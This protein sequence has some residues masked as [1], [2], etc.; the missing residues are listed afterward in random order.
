MRNKMEFEILIVIVLLLNVDVVASENKFIGD[1]LSVPCASLAFSNESYVQ[2][3]IDKGDGSKV[4]ADWSIGSKKGQLQSFLPCRDTLSCSAPLD[5]LRDG[6][7]FQVILRFKGMIAERVLNIGDGDGTRIP[8]QNV[9]H[10]SNNDSMRMY[11]FKDRWHVIPER[12]KRTADRE[13]HYSTYLKR[14]HR[15][16]KKQ[17]KHYKRFNKYRKTVWKKP[18]Q[19]VYW[20]RQRLWRKSRSGLLKGQ[21]N[22]KGRDITG[23][24]IRD[25]IASSSEKMGRVTKNLSEDIIKLQTSLV[26]DIE[27]PPV[28][29]K[30]ATSLGIKGKAVDLT[31]DVIKLLNS[32][33]RKIDTELRNGD[34][35]RSKDVT[36]LVNSL[37]KK[38]DPANSDVE[39]TLNISPKPPK[40]TKQTKGTS[41]YKNSRRKIKETNKDLSHIKRNKN[42]KQ[43]KSS[44]LSRQRTVGR[45]SRRNEVSQS[46]K[47]MTVRRKNGTPELEKKNRIKYQKRVKS[48]FNR[49]KKYR[50][51]KQSLRKNERVPTQKR[52][53]RRKLNQLNRQFNSKLTQ[54]RQ[55]FNRITESRKM[56]SKQGSTLTSLKI[57]IPTTNKVNLT[58]VAT[59]KDQFKNTNNDNAVADKY[60]ENKSGNRIPRKRPNVLKNE[61]KGSQKRNTK[62][63]Y[64]FGHKRIDR[65]TKGRVSLSKMRSRLPR[66][67][68]KHRLSKATKKSNLAKYRHDV[69]RKY[70]KKTRKDN[71]V[72]HKLNYIKEPMLKQRAKQEKLM[73]S[74]RVKMKNINKTIKKITPAGKKVFLK[75]KIR[76]NDP[77]ETDIKISSKENSNVTNLIDDGISQSTKTLVVSQHPLK[78]K[79]FFPK[80]QRELQTRKRIKR[81]VDIRPSRKRSDHQSKKTRKSTVTKHRH[82]VKNRSK[83]R[84]IGKGRNGLLRVPRKSK[85]SKNETK[86]R[87]KKTKSTEAKHRHKVKR[88]GIFKGR[89]GLSP[90]KSRHSTK[91]TKHPSK[92]IRKS[93]IVKHR[94]DLKSRSK[95][96]G[97]HKGRSRLLPRKSN[98]SKKETKYQPKKR[99]SKK[100]K[101]RHKAKRKETGKGRNGL[102]PRKPRHK[103]KHSSKKTR[104]NVATKYR[105]EKKKI[106]KKKGILKSKNRLLSRKSMQSKREN[107]NR[108]KKIRKSMVAKHR[109]N[110]KTRK[111][112]I[113]KHR[114]KVKRRSKRKGTGKGKNGLLPTKYKHP[115]KGTKDWSK[116]PRKS[117]LA[118]HRHTA[119]RISK[120]KG[121]GYGRNG[122]NGLL[123]R[124]PRHS[125]KN[126]KYWSK[127]SRKSKVAKHR[128]TAKRISKRKGSGNGRNG[129]LPRKPRHS[130]KNTKHWSKK[131][132]KSKVA[133]H[134]HT[135]KRISKRKGSG[136]SGNVRNGLLPRKPRHTKKNTKHWS[137]KSRKSKVA[138][139]RHTAKRISK[140]KGSV[141]GRNVRNGLLPRKPRHSKKEAKHQSKK[142]RK[143]KIAK[144]SDKVELTSKRNG[145]FKGRNR[146][147]PKKSIR[148]SKKENKHRPRKA[149]L[150]KM[151]KPRLKVKRMKKKNGIHKAK[152]IVLPKQSRHSKKE[153]KHRETTMLAK[154]WKSL[155][156][157]KNGISKAIKRVLP[158]KTRHS[159]NK[160][161][162]LSKKSRK[163]NQSKQRHGVKQ[164]FMTNRMSNARNM[165]LPRRINPSTEITKHEANKKSTTSHMGH[166]EHN[167]KRTL[168]NWISKAR[169]KL[170]P[171]K[172]HHSKK[173]T[174]HPL[175][176]KSTT[177]H[178]GHLEH[179][180]KRQSQ[181]RV[182]KARDRNTVLPRKSHHLKKNAKRPSKEKSRSSNVEHS[183][184]YMKG[185]LKK[186]ISKARERLLP[187]KSKPFEKEINHGAKKKIRNSN[188]AKKKHNLKRTSSSKRNKTTERL[189]QKGFRHSKN[190]TKHQSNKTSKKHV[191]KHRDNVNVEGMSKIRKLS[192]GTKGQSQN[193]NEP[194]HNPDLK[195]ISM[196]WL[197]KGVKILPTNINIT[198]NLIENKSKSREKKAKSVLLKKTK[199]INVTKKLFNKP[200]TRNITRE[201]EMFKVNNVELPSVESRSTINRTKSDNVTDD[202]PSLKQ[203]PST[204]YTL[205]YILS[206][207]KKPKGSKRT[208]KKNKTSKARTRLSWKGSIQ[209][210]KEN[211]LP[212]NKGMRKKSNT[213]AKRPSKKKKK[214][215]ARKRFYAQRV[216]QLKK[217][218]R[219]RLRNKNGTKQSLDP[220][221][222]STSKGLKR[223]SFKRAKKSRKKSKGKSKQATNI[224]I[225]L[226]VVKHE[227]RSRK[228]E[229]SIF[230]KN[231]HLQNWNFGNSTLNVMKHES[232]SR[233]NKSRIFSKNT[234]LQNWNFGNSTAVNHLRGK[235]VN[236]TLDNNNRTGNATEHDQNLTKL[237]MTNRLFKKG[238]HL[239]RKRA[240]KGKK[241]KNILVQRNINIILND[242]K[243]KSKS[244]KT[245]KDMG[246]STKTRPSEKNIPWN[247]NAYKRKKLFSKILKQSRE[248]N[249]PKSNQGN[250]TNKQLE[251]NRISW[252][253]SKGRAVKISFD[254][255]GGSTPAT[256]SFRHFK[257][258][259]YLAQHSK[260]L[261]GGHQNPLVTSPDTRELL[262]HLHFQLKE[263]SRQHSIKHLITNVTNEQNKTVKG[264]SLYEPVHLIMSL[265]G[266]K[267]LKLKDITHDEHKWKGEMKVKL[268]SSV[269]HLVL[270]GNIEV[271]ADE[272]PYNPSNI[273]LNVTNR[274]IRTGRDVPLHYPNGRNKSLKLEQ[275]VKN[276]EKRLNIALVGRSLNTFKTKPIHLIMTLKGNMFVK[277]RGL[278]HDNHKWHG[279]MRVDLHS[280]Y[281]MLFV[282]GS[283]RVRAQ[284]THNMGEHE[285]HNPSEAKL[286]KSRDVLPDDDIEHF[287]K[288]LD[289][290]SNDVLVGDADFSGDVTQ[291]QIEP[292]KS[293][294]RREILPN[295]DQEYLMK[296]M[297]GQSNDALI[298]GVKKN[299]HKTN[300]QRKWHNKKPRHKKQKKLE[301]K[302]MKHHKKP[303]Y[304]KLMKYG[305]K[306]KLNNVLV[307]DDDLSA[308]V[309]ESEANPY[310]KLIHMSTTDAPLKIIEK[311]TP[312]VNT[313]NNVH[314]TRTQSNKK[315]K[316]HKKKKHRF[317]KLLKSERKQEMKH[318]DTHSAR[319][320]INMETIGKTAVKVNNMIDISKMIENKLA[321]EFFDH[322]DKSKANHTSLEENVIIGHNKFDMKINKDTD[323]NV[324][325]KIQLDKNIEAKI[326]ND[327]RKAETRG[328]SNWGAWSLCTATCGSK[329][330]R[331]RE[332]YCLDTHPRG[333]HGQHEQIKRCG[334]LQ[335]CPVT[336]WSEWQL[337]SGCSDSCGDGTKERRRT[338]YNASKDKRCLGDEVEHTNCNIQSCATPT[339]LSVATATTA[340]S[341]GIR[342]DWGSWLAWSFCP[343]TCGTA[344]ETRTRGCYSKQ[345]HALRHDLCD[346]NY[347]RETKPCIRHACDQSH[348]AASRIIEEGGETK[349]V[350]KHSI[351]NIIEVY[352][353]SPKGIK[354]T[355]ST[356]DKR[357]RLDGSTLYILNATREDEG[358]YHCVVLGEAGGSE[359]GDAQLGVMNCYS[360]PCLNGGKCIEFD[361]NSHIMNNKLRCE[362]P[363]NYRG[364]YC[365]IA[366]HSHTLLLV[367]IVLVALLLFMFGSMVSWW[368][369]R[370]I[371]AKKTK[372]NLVFGT[373]TGEDSD[374]HDDFPD[375]DVKT[376]SALGNRSSATKKSRKSRES[377]DSKNTR[378]LYENNNMKV[379]SMGKK[380]KKK[381]SI[382]MFSKH[383]QVLDTLSSA[384]QGSTTMINERSNSNDPVHVPS[385]KY[386]DKSTSVHTIE[387]ENV[388]PTK[389][390]NRHSLQD[391]SVELGDYDNESG[392]T[393]S[394]VKDTKTSSSQ[395]HTKQSKVPAT[396]PS[397]TQHGSK[398][399]VNDRTNSKDPKYMASKE[400][401]KNSAS[402]HI[403]EGVYENVPST[404]TIHKSSHQDTKMEADDYLEMSGLTN[405]RIT[406][407]QVL[408]NTPSIEQ[409]KTS[410]STHM[411]EHVYENVPSTNTVN[412]GSFR[413]TN[414]EPDD[415]IEM[416]TLRN[417]KQSN[418]QAPLGVPSKHHPENP[419]SV[420]NI[421]SLQKNAPSTYTVKRLSPENTGIETT[422]S[423]NSVRSKLM[424]NEDETS[425][426]QVVTKYSYVLDNIPSDT[427]Q[428]ATTAVNHRRISKDPVHVSSKKH[429]GK[430]T[431]VPMIKHLYEKVPSRNILPST[432]KRGPAGV[433]NERTRS[434]NPTHVPSLNQREK[435]TYVPMVKKFYEKVPSTNILPS[436]IRH[437]PS[438]VVNETIRNQDPVCVSS[439][440]QHEKPT[441]VH[442]IKSKNS[443][444]T[445]M[446][447]RRSTRSTNFDQ[448]TGQMNIQK[449]DQSQLYKLR[450]ENEVD[451]KSDSAWSEVLKSVR[452]Q[453]KIDELEA[454]RQIK[455]KTIKNGRDNVNSNPAKSEVK[456]STSSHSD[457]IADHISSRTL[458]FPKGGVKKHLAKFAY[459]KW[460]SNVIC[461]SDSD[462]EVDYV[463]DK[464]KV[465]QNQQNLQNTGRKMNLDKSKESTSGFKTPKAST[466]SIFMSD[467][468]APR[469][470]SESHLVGETPDG[471]RRTFTHNM[472][473]EKLMKSPVL[474]RKLLR[475]ENESK[476]NSDEYTTEQEWTATSPD[477]SPRRDI[478]SDFKPISSTPAE[479]TQQTS[480]GDGSKVD[481]IT[482]VEHTASFDVKHELPHTNPS[483][484]D[485]SDNGEYGLPQQNSSQYQGPDNDDYELPHSNSS[486]YNGPD[487]DYYGVP[488]SNPSQYDGLGSHDYG[489]P[490]PIQLQYDEPNNDDNDLPGP[491]QFKYD[492][493]D[494][495]D[496]RLPDP[497][498]L[499]YDESNNDDY[500]LPGPNETQ[501][502]EPN[503]DDYGLPGQNET[504][505]DD[506]NNDNYGLPGQNETRYDEPNNDDFRRPDPNRLQYDEPNADYELSHFNQS[507]YDE[508]KNGEDTFDGNVYHIRSIEN[509]ET[510][511]RIPRMLPDEIF[512]KWQTKVQ[513]KLSNVSDTFS[514]SSG[515]STT[516]LSIS[517]ATSK[518]SNIEDEIQEL[519]NES[520]DLS[521]IDS[522]I[523]IENLGNQ[524]FTE[525]KVALDKHLAEADEV[526]S[527]FSHTNDLRKSK[528][529]V[530]ISVNED[531]FSANSSKS[532]MRGQSLVSEKETP[533]TISILLGENIQSN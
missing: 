347:K 160:T 128:H 282:R 397:A 47:R 119:K 365:E 151:A 223:L 137:K 438:A 311:E 2:L 436:T 304:K 525:L 464:Q 307:K 215:K 172:F 38:I 251:N 203:K 246:F 516:N 27:Y 471:E 206:K 288:K 446:V 265:Q 139:H 72:K 90:R 402:T 253:K 300:G 141:N 280:Q 254:K 521:N 331:L 153:T 257:R 240:K 506:P 187:T 242:L 185:T 105:H 433:I 453:K 191:A 264:I 143:G 45:K 465:V 214:S 75:V 361:K 470:I 343:V 330:H 333:C 512:N 468:H 134:R 396:L 388:Q 476:E 84:R 3:K 173:R 336:N 530:D 459:K 95:K 317:E 268:N 401:H 511:W 56:K 524:S 252:K 426:T 163:I 7:R 14:K 412:K 527:E 62:T 168:T 234:H 290:S 316:K 22:Y 334:V 195:D 108:S 486:Q 237:S 382:Q 262:G 513:Q 526:N 466:D 392:K 228:N 103:N 278:L 239:S 502:D 289:K 18:K 350:C 167:M 437:G 194:K 477:L 310:K 158:K 93:K 48:Y 148:H 424:E 351:P 21:S 499:Q 210:R 26:E 487:N 271:M 450:T 102:L 479:I 439:K 510:N 514:D 100:A 116:K 360:S 77:K 515:I 161:K 429:H 152:Y 192:K 518:I 451:S 11:S 445:S 243:K 101:H 277:L 284:N 118:K 201:S 503:N 31:N 12:F 490:D 292:Y 467:P 97:I 115:K 428:G 220:Y 295:D 417:Q 180:V 475:I 178:L 494:N 166:P 355:K 17:G 37:Q 383:S 400:H 183:E 71:L 42:G 362:C 342:G 59:T 531:F 235:P 349:L 86:H 384:K 247:K 156:T 356:Q 52:S 28:K 442:T 245:K 339:T 315:Q 270:K 431:Y 226:N 212:S 520:N 313:E 131:S 67:H 399:T 387:N 327:V 89:N 474:Q 440:K 410:T 430:P 395:L 171:R 133:K 66:K 96:K 337:W 204:K 306:H 231:T 329:G 111:S 403:N 51:N 501:Y 266:D 76:S 523:L 293:R 8:E 390:V 411:V 507:Q 318:R 145:I 377:V 197:S 122:R 165:L 207:H 497:N 373:L 354:L 104:K 335:V 380:A 309:S 416:S 33:K 29:K 488:H 294:K 298:G 340:S 420:H 261:K 369:S 259:H 174:K 508:V 157:S 69:K 405:Q 43:R 413:D 367:I 505:Y 138:K 61:T 60:R 193:N 447:N 109:H 249:Q 376:Q 408:T 346:G 301:R 70:K 404:N 326:L 509:R 124:K 393:N 504:Q 248:A 126:T 269:H 136:N 127:K 196:T 279:Q 63:K 372:N 221:V 427:K 78:A 325:N 41:T 482:Y 473:L 99:K 4:K 132:R 225:T 493:P 186:W 519:L 169:D 312:P 267:F 483:H 484:Y 434:Q 112:K 485:E 82:K 302:S 441:S 110:E 179:N 517:N 181:K 184:Q 16:L 98:H 463:P 386:L 456:Q 123:P 154:P 283:V 415:Y 73:N 44:K 332:R 366:N 353:V 495:D 314:K 492:E 498:H 200:N 125:K 209:S 10:L 83:R 406:N 107:K 106:S 421:K 54:I 500:G 146:L 391:T 129:V 385:K 462:Q 81:S 256:R 65:M 448:I 276:E 208:S 213:N 55:A 469:N 202:R 522:A 418:S 425:S 182:S 205:H 273:L 260:H 389:M 19:Q 92:K 291:R 40:I 85:H 30:T 39:L 344:V 217:E 461:D 114:H 211:K 286:R 371:V 299:V 414:I 460:Y 435:P 258:M 218:T 368:M 23:S 189:F 375:M 20:N 50:S 68:I 321:N 419:T 238:N 232:R 454:K 305:R 219:H 398:A 323:I 227:S 296:N 34:N 352:W 244:K 74:K 80:Q 241:S 255:S 147:L 236:I 489:L 5:K 36:K 357:H 53:H 272:D 164:P 175:M 281:H 150:S 199:Y 480:D 13:K 230:S 379:D 275:I 188:M 423:Y 363:P 409:H 57:S 91:E 285:M 274:Y 374:P 378:S 297:D 49:L 120:R 287:V 155:R 149:K 328:W 94:H 338:C 394:I 455:N 190:E 449:I 370:F 64:E 407:C 320:Q 345:G 303:R 176:E 481:N 9:E 478:F 142:T 15:K 216:K 250:G 121:S 24:T 359:T 341:S 452:L 130:K 1:C 46:I 319:N 88:K 162:R 144:H 348:V 6:V 533:S 222:L 324:L 32:M 87:G 135:T 381:S 528:S 364:K 233:K 224:N 358:M 457:E 496:F 263:G 322:K 35:H 444:S 159:R 117:K 308:D 140:K 58:S 529:G 443:P 472:N 458:N 229:S 25:R 79:P 113:T 198:V 432:T 170:L 532:D 491:K 422:D 177:S